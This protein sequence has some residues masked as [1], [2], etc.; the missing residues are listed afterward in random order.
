MIKKN[1]YI[2]DLDD[3]ESEE[4]NIIKVYLKNIK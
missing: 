3:E 1:N 2:R 4:I